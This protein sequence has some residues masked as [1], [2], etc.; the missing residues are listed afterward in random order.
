MADGGLLLDGGTTT[1]EFARLL[2]GRP[3]QIV[4]N[5]LPIANLFVAA[6]AMKR[7]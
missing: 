1:L 2:V 3:L 7:K 4:T 5:S 6:A